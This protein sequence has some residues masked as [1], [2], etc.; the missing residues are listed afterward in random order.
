MYNLTADE[1]FFKWEALASTLGSR[2]LNAETIDIL[3]SNIHRK[4]T[5]PETKSNLNMNIVTSKR[6]KGPPKLGG[7]IYS[8][9]KKPL[10]GPINGA[11]TGDSSRAGV[12]GPSKVQFVG[13]NMDGDSRS[14]RRCEYSS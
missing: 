4:T 9:P 7:S 14:T 10:A 8:T 6:L 2:V 11:S 12:A 3:R 13:Y 5:K 1:L